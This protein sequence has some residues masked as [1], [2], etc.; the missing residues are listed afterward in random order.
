MMKMPRID[1]CDFVSLKIEPYVINVEL[2]ILA[3]IHVPR[4][5]IRIIDFR[6]SAAKRTG[7]SMRIFVIYI[8]QLLT[9]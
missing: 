7:S 6:K 8:H 3:Y 2:K 9:F 1:S 5:S 4:L